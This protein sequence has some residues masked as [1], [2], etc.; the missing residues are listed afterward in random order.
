MKKAGDMY[1]LDDDDFFASIFEKYGDH[2]ETHHLEVGL[3]YVQQW[4]VALDGGAS[5]GSWTRRLSEKF[6]NVVAFEPVDDIYDCLVL[7]TN[8]C[9]NVKLHHA[10]LGEDHKSVTVG[11]GKIYPNAGCAT[12]IGE[13][14]TPMVPI[15][16]LELNVLDFLK[17][18]IEGY[19]LK[20][21][22]GAKETLLRCRPV[23]MFE[24]NMRGEVEHG[25]ALGLCGE[26]LESIGAV[27]LDQINKDHVYGWTE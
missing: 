15:D 21:L 6:D 12:Y 8:Q 19:E 10:A 27:Q 2:F 24:E 17:I 14:D 16:S 20:A 22:E 13:G 3:Q 4:R 5:Y 1:I 26:F 9:T 7:N 25:I 11:E 23:I 18:D